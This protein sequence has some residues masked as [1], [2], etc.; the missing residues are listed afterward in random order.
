MQ[1]SFRYTKAAA[2]GFYGDGPAPETAG[3]AAFD[4][5]A[6]LDEPVTLI[7][8][9][10][11]VLISS[12]IAL[13]MSAHPGIC[14]LV[15]PRSGN[16]HKKG[17]VLGNT[18]GLIDSDYQGDIMV[19]AWNRNPPEDAARDLV[20]SPGDRI[21]QL[22]FV[23]VLHPTLSRVADFTDETARGAGGF[24]STGHS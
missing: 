11:P 5:I 4:L 24:G 14:A 23:P 7:C 18:V 16:G 19:S 3:S 13:D 22:M 21:A 8:Q 2:A 9:A 17:L 12:G 6:V 10:P 15:L 20:V 1:V